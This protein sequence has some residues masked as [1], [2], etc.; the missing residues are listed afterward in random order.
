MHKKEKEV[1]VI[2]NGTLADDPKNGKKRQHG[3]PLM[4]KVEL[5]AEHKDGDGKIISVECV[6]KDG[7]CQTLDPSHIQK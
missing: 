4:T 3:F 6:D 5:V 7:L 2:G 1:L